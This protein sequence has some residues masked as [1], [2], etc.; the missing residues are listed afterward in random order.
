MVGGIAQCTQSFH[1]QIELLWE[2][3]HQTQNVLNQKGFRLVPLNLR[4]DMRHQLTPGVLDTL[5]CPCQ[6]ERL[7]W[8]PDCVKVAIFP[9]CGGERAAGGH[10]VVQVVRAY[11]LLD[12]FPG[13]GTLMPCSTHFHVAI[14]SKL[15]QTNNGPL[16]WADFLRVLVNDFDLLRCAESKLG[17][18][19]FGAKP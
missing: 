5:F 9:Q 4:R 6:T 13:A 1:E 17:C 7:T 14:I 16:F 19:A 8:E 3:L 2:E 15:F 12:E 11:G 10:V 18:Q